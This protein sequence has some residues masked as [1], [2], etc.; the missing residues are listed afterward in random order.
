MM[1]AIGLAAALAASVAFDSDVIPK[2]KGE[3]ASACGSSPAISVT[4]DAFG[5]DES[6]AGALINSQLRFLVTAFTD[7]CKTPA[8]KPEVIKQIA[9]VVVRQAYGATEP[10]L[11]ISNGTLF[12]EYLWVAGEPAPDAAFV[13][14]ELVDRLRGGEPEAP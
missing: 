5:E 4:W 7:V 9:K 8:L 12:V 2:V 10:I 13:G 3:I 1:F 11:Y 6:G 14:A